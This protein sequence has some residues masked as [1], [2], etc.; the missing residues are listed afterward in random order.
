MVGV[1]SG[2]VRGALEGSVIE[3]TAGLVFGNR[4][5]SYWMPFISMHTINCGSPVSAFTKSQN[6]KTIG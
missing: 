3:G 1:V 4:T 5:P 6:K 2:G